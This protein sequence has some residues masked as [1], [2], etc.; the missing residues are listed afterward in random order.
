M[1]ET[2]Y[3][4]LFEPIILNG[5]YF[6]NRIFASPQGTSLST[7]G[8]QPTTENMMFYERK[9]MGGCAAVCY[10]D[11]TVDCEIGAGNGPH[12]H[13]DDRANGVHLNHMA[14]GVS[15]HGAVASIE[16]SHCGSSARVSFD[17]GHTIYGAVATNT[18][19]Q[20]HAG[21]IWAEEMPPEIIE[22]TIKKFADAAWFVHHEGFGMVTVHGG[23]GWLLTQFMHPSNTR[24]D[25]WDGSFENRMRFPIAVCEAI[26]KRCPKLVIEMR[27]S[28]SEVYEGGYDLDYGI[29]IA[30][31]LDKS[32]FVDL[33]H[34]SA[35]CHERDEVFTIT[36]PNMF[37]PDGVN[38][39][40]AAEIKKHV[41]TPVAC[42]GALNDVE[43]MEEIIATG[44]ADVVELARQFSADF[45]FPRKALEGRPEDIR[46]CMRCQSCFSHVLQGQEYS[47]AI[48]PQMG[49]YMEQKYPRVPADPKRVIVAGGGIAGMTAALTAA[50]RG[51]DVVLLEK[52]DKLGGVLTCE[53]D[54]PFKVHLDQYLTQQARFV[55]EAGVDVRLETAATPELVESLE[56]DAVIAA[57]GAREFVAPIPGIDGA[58]V[59]SAQKVYT[60]TELAG[61]NIVILGGGLVGQELAVY[62]GMKGRKCTIVEMLPELN[63][64]GNILQQNALYL[65]YPLYGTQILTSTKALQVLPDGVLVEGPNGEFELAADTIV[66][67]MGM[68]P[69]REEALA[70]RWCA[71]D[72]HLVGDALASRS[73]R[74]ANWDAYQAALDIGMQI[75]E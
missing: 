42:V 1:F 28:G 33:I 22:R 58:N 45:D 39:K 8:N 20:H 50:K 5:T 51:H 74:E 23:H 56:G 10:G 68:K 61:G 66:T 72:F 63:A 12:V 19:N 14:R 38:V 70:L 15:R 67:A 30:K 37:L 36:H 4:H 48:N 60:D 53:K 21:E 47:C 57:L 7:Y 64:G 17:Q 52:T 18:E 2:K 3:P 73:I 43:M 6:K 31:A 13:L 46:R 26:R 32:G 34:V 29:E 40:Y 41:E 44:Q 49:W 9:A 71:R 27:I 54:V 35:G 75:V 24:K 69:R 62:L 25:E 55:R 11:A 59:V 65:Q 16:L